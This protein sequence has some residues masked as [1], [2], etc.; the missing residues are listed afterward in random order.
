MEADNLNILSKEEILHHVRSYCATNIPSATP[1]KLR[2]PYAGRVYD[3]EEIVNLVDSALEFWLTNGRYTEAFE[4]EL[5]KYLDIKYC[6]FVNSGSS[7]NLL[8]FMALTVP[9]LGSR[10]IR[11]GDEVITVACGFPTTVS[12]IIQYG[13]VPVFVDI[14]IPSYN[15]D[16][17][18]LE[19]ALSPK[20]KAVMIAHTL[21]NPFDLVAVKS[22]CDKH[23]LWLIE[24]NCDALGAEF[25][26]DGRYCKTGTVGDIGTSSFYPAHHITTGEGVQFIP[27]MKRCIGLYVLCGIGVEPVSVLREKMAFADTGLKDNL[28]SFRKATTINMYTAIL[29]II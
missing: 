1:E 22:F 21:G 11:R 5:A 25:L 7:A 10:A 29:V 2:I 16:A 27:T 23:G 4:T 24:D 18:Q 19:G 26:V 12:P 15:I 20:T 8:A 14:T 13:A 28:G 9:E 3:E 6:S 17:A